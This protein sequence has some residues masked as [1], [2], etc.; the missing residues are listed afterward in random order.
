LDGNRWENETSEHGF[1][2]DYARNPTLIAGFDT[3]KFAIGR[4]APLGISAFGMLPRVRR[5]YLLT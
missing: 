2:S 5:S 3:F 1:K 4:I